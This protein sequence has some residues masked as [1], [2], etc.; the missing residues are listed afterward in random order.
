MTALIIGVIVWA[1]LAG[2]AWAIVYTGSPRR[3]GES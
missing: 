3:R 2:W 1:I